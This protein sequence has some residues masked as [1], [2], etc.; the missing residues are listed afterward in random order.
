MSTTEQL[1]EVLQGLLGQSSQPV[2]VF[3]ATWPF[4]RVLGMSGMVVSNT[5]LSLLQEIIG[6]NRSLLMPS[7]ARGYRNGIAELDTEPSTT[8][9]LSEHFRQ[10]PQTIRT[11]SAFFSYNVLGP[12]DNLL[13]SLRPEHAWGDGSVYHWMEE[14]NARFLMLGTHPTHCSYLH[15]VEW[16]LRDK[17]NYR[18][19]KTFTGEIHYRGQIVPMKETLLVR[20]LEPE[21][22]NDFT[23]IQDILLDGGMT[24][25][26]LNGIAISAMDAKDMCQAYWKALN[27]D[28]YLTVKN[29][30]LFEG[31]T[32]VC[33]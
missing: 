20:S 23:I 22:I 17:I 25:T 27:Q 8:G 33:R 30:E 18:H 13:F 10:C 1:K 29:R 16:L 14:N 24:Q 5:L 28:P 12:D 31:K 32:K 3:S 15:R 19:L 6:E 26:S 4:S 9:M 2:V 7:F 21:M 11:L